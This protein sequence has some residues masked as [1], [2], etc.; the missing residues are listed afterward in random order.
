MMMM[1]SYWWWL[2]VDCYA[3]LPHTYDHTRRTILH[4]TLRCDTSPVA[5][6]PTLRW[7]MRAIFVHHA[8]YD[9]IPDDDVLVFATVGRYFVIVRCYSRDDGIDLMMLCCL[10]T[11]CCPI[12]HTPVDVMCYHALTY[13]TYCFLMISWWWWWWY[14]R[15]INL[16]PMI[17]M[18]IVLI[19]R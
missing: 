8:R 14:L 5:F 13:P 16:L 15:V 17:L 18:M 12:P 4:R 19:H 9:G 2:R 1:I 7:L 10:H 6:V 11:T 3:R